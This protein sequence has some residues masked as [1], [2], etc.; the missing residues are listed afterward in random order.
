MGHK[1][2]IIAPTLI[3]IR[4]TNIVAPRS[5]RKRRQACAPVP[6]CQTIVGRPTLGLTSL[7][8]H[9]KDGLEGK[10]IDR[11]DEGKAGRGR[12]N[13]DKGSACLDG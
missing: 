11:G 6:A 4:I 2:G 1:L 5:G 13:I 10:K 9:G 8:G 7:T 12:K 3:R